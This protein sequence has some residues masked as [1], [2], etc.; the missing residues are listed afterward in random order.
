MNTPEK[1]TSEQLVRVGLDL[2]KTQGERNPD[3]LYVATCRHLGCQ[4]EVASFGAQAIVNSLEFGMQRMERQALAAAVKFETIGQ[5]SLF[6][7]LIPEHHIPKGWKA[8]I[9]R[10]VND[11]LKSRAEIK[12][13]NAEELERAAEGARREAVAAA[14]DAG[15]SQ[16]VIDALERAGLDPAQVTYEQAIAHSEAF[17]GRGGATAG[18]SPRKPLR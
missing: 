6:G 14:H 17:H 13:A 4:T 8:K 18:A 10:E 11:W 1:L 15:A 16:Q 5:M 7:D 9:A 3:A 12:Q 2:F